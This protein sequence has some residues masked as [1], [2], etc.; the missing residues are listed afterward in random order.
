MCGFYDVGL[1][2]SPHEISPDRRDPGRVERIWAEDLF[3]VFMPANISG[4]LCSR[5]E[6]ERESD[7]RTEK[8]G[9]RSFQHF[10]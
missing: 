7:G 4:K 3:V 8:K 9:D 10:Q 6:S 5:D 1:H 2:D